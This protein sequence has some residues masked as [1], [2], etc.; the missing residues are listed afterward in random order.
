MLLYIVILIIGNPGTPVCGKPPTP[1]VHPLNLCV[2]AT[3]TP[4]IPQS[5]AGT[6]DLP[7]NQQTHKQYIV[8]FNPQET[9]YYRKHIFLVFECMAEDLRGALKKWLGSTR[10]QLG[11]LPQFLGH[12]ASS[13]CFDSLIP[14]EPT[15]TIHTGFVFLGAS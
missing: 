6:G 4:T 10:V 3:P 11:I 8:T 9:F 7:E 12:G 1:C 13:C 15:C 5:M 14:A 2:V